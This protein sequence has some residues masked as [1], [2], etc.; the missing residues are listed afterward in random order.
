[1]CINIPL[2]EMYIYFY[3]KTMGLY[4]FGIFVLVIPLISLHF[5]MF[6][7]TRFLFLV[8]CRFKPYRKHIPVF[9]VIF[10]DVGQLLALCYVIKIFIYI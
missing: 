2:N 6:H 1:M 9:E 8:Q 4:L 5:I 7:D 3:D 10:V